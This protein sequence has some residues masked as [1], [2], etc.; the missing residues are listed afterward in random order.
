M[1]FAIFKV[2]NV[3]LDQLHISLIQRGRSTLYAVLG[4]S[5]GWIN[6]YVPIFSF[7]YEHIA[8]TNRSDCSSQVSLQSFATLPAVSC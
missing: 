4:P 3:W 1:N 2:K 7:Y 5:Y 6:P 8:E